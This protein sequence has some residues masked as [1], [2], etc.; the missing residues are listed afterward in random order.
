MSFVMKYIGTIFRCAAQYRTERLSHIGLN[1]AQC[2]YIL[3]ISHNP[4][5]S[6]DK[7]AR[8]M[9]INKS[10]VTRQLQILEENGFI[11]RKTSETDKRTTEVYLTRKAIENMPIVQLVLQEWNDYITEGFSDEEKACFT[12]LLDR[13]AQ[14]SRMYADKANSSQN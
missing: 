13:A 3:N 7:L 11:Q 14:R 4:G 10:N 5:I 12:E 2:I 8:I 1:G 6:Q 9:Y